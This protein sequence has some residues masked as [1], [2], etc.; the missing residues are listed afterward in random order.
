MIIMAFLLFVLGSCIRI[1]ASAE[2]GGEYMPE[3]LQ[4][5]Y[6]IPAGSGCIVARSHC[7]IT[8][9]EGFGRRIDYMMNTLSVIGR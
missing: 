7:Y 4:K 2:K 5:A 1:D 8:G 9:A 3:Y 6:I